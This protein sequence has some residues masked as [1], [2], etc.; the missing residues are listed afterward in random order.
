MQQRFERQF[1]ATDH[2]N[3]LYRCYFKGAAIPVTAG[4][5]DAFTEEYVLRLYVILSA[6]V[7]A[8]AILLGV[9]VMRTG[10]GSMSQ[11]PPA[12]IFAGMVAISIVATGWM[13]WVFRAPARA[14][15]GRKPVDFGLSK[16]AA[17]AAAFKRMS[18]GRLT[19]LWFFGA[20]TAFM[21]RDNGGPGGYS[22]G[23]GGH[24]WQILGELLMLVAAVQAFRKWRFE[25]AHP[26]SF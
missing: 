22:W 8:L 4:E 25:R 12:Q 19:V 1:E 14:L 21:R 23:P 2:G 26:N 9:L 3:Y 11:V 24:G 6:M 5:R 7:L 16:E 10:T 17:R 20:V 13:E 18:Y 15:R